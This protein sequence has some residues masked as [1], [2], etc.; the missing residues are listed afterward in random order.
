MLRRRFIASDSCHMRS[1][2]CYASVTLRHHE[3]RSRERR[4][5]QVW[6]AYNII[7][8]C[9]ICI[10]VSPHRVVHPRDSISHLPG[11]IVDGLGSNMFGTVTL[12]DGNQVSHRPNPG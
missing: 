9:H 2:K 1:R 6:V 4:T 8:V 12:N 10:F 5:G 7:Y 3:F 11:F